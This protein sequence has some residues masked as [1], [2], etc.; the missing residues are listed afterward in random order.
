MSQ[1]SNLLSNIEKLENQ[2]YSSGFDISKFFLSDQDSVKKLIKLKNPQMSKDDID[3][4]VDSHD[5]TMSKLDLEENKLAS[6]EENL[7]LKRDKHLTPEEAKNQKIIR[8]KVRE[9]RK[10]KRKEDIEVAKR[11]YKDR[12]KSY[13]DE[14]K[15]IK[16][17]IRIS[18]FSLV[19]NS[20]DLSKKL[21]N[22][23]IQTSSTIPGVAIMM[24]APPF[25]VPGAITLAISVINLLMDIITKLK[26]IVQLLPPL[27][28][29]EII[30][31]DKGLSSISS[32]LNPIL[33]IIT[34]LWIPIGALSKVI[35]A[36][37][38]GISSSLKKN[39]NRVFKRATRKLKKLGHLY[40]INKRGDEYTV[41]DTILYSYDGDDIDDV[42][43]LLDT[44]KISNNKVIDYK[45]KI[46]DKTFEEVLDDMQSQLDSI[47]SD[48]NLPNSDSDIYSQ[49]LYDI[50]LPDG[51]ILVNIS[52][53]G[54]ED[55]K[56]KYKIEFTPSSI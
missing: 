36:I 37:T 33:S 29:L 27:K 39:K 42:K 43:E 12:L 15:E 2:V 19:E 34:A 14:C 28:K 51:T 38:G 22:A 53:E 32:V 21:I 11:I 44:F 31:D 48:N 18:A 13:Y 1:Y 55:I 9:E 3:L 26:E 8:A 10:K 54:L 20:V 56:N 35:S 24:A 4:M 52:D 50:E 23:V 7:A 46:G 30:M 16:N 41:D 45:Q 17:E 5:D 40:K 47:K 49:Y 6:I 25:N